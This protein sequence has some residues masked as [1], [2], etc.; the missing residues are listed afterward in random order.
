MGKIGRNTPCLCGSG[1]KF[2]HCC[3]TLSSGNRQQ[4]TAPSPE[5][6]AH[7]QLQLARQ[8]AREYQR[9][10]MQGLGRP[11]SSFEDHQHGYRIVCVANQVRWS[12]G[13]RTFFDFLSDYKGVM[14]P[15]WG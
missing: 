11:I 3:G 8:E 12:K 14:T 15:E 9:R 4:A 2:K 13:W 5:T 1:K 6:I 7:M 10:L